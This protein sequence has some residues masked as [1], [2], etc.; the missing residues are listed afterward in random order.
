MESKYRYEK[1]RSQVCFFFLILFF[2]TFAGCAKEE[3][4]TIDPSSFEGIQN[5]DII[6]RLGTGFFSNQFK[7]YSLSEKLY[8]HVGIVDQYGDS[9]FVIHAEASELTGVG[10]VKREAIQVFLDGITTWG[11]YRINAGDSVR[12]NI[13]VY[14]KGYF[15]DKTPFDL[16]FDASEDKKV[17]CTE[18]VALSV[19][20]AVNDSLIK[21]DMNLGRRKVYGIDNV[22]LLP[23][24]E[25]IIKVTD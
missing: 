6:C 3:K 18:L 21:P 14:A 4:K 13:A 16:D 11:V 2:L 25:T 9:L 17:Y 7:N 8:S 12:N 24:I 5:G 10:H 20:K 15:I 1:I 22:Y 23:D 19:N